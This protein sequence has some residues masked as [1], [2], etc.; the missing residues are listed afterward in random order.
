MIGQMRTIK[1]FL[2]NFLKQKQ[3]PVENENEN[4]ITVIATPPYSY[5]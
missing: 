3:H 1:D 5:R 2:V 4:K